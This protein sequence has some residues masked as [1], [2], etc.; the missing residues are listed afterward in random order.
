MFF[1][2]LSYSIPAV[3]KCFWSKRVKMHLS[4]SKMLDTVPMLVKWWNAT[5]SVRS[6]NQSEQKSKKR[7]H[8]TGTMIHHQQTKNRKTFSHF[9]THFLTKIFITK[10]LFFSSLQSIQTVVDPIG[11]G[12]SSNNYLSLSFL[13]TFPSTTQTKTNS[14]EC[15]LDFFLFVRNDTRSENI[16]SVVYYLTRKKNSNG[17]RT[18]KKLMVFE[19][20]SNIKYFYEAQYHSNNIAQKIKWTFIPLKLHEHNTILNDDLSY[21]SNANSKK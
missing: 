16:L 8:N 21:W 14:I 17:I 20:E 7:R 12:H 15:N 18:Y 11:V 9:L 6:S 5:K 1:F 2:C 3:K 4:L 10:F 13:V 19:I